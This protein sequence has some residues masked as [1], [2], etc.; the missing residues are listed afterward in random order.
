MSRN[1]LVRKLVDTYRELG[2][3]E[4][5]RCEAHGDGKPHFER[6]DC[7]HP[8]LTDEAT[9]ERLIEAERTTTSAT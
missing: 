9:R 6:R 2:T 1:A 8:H 4:A 7:V 3:R 5:V